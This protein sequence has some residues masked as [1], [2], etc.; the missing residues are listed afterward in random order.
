MFKQ[1]L[2]LVTE[3]INIK[4]IN[5]II[6]GKSEAVI[7]TGQLVSRIKLDE[8]TDICPNCLGKLKK[9][10]E[11][12][13]KCPN[14]SKYCLVKT[15]VV[16][17]KMVKVVCTEDEAR[18]IEMEY[19]IERLKH[20]IWD[21]IFIAINKQNIENKFLKLVEEWNNTL[22]KYTRNDLNFSLYAIMLVEAKNQ[23]NFHALSYFYKQQG[24][25]L[26]EEGKN[27][28]ELFALA[29]KY[30]KLYEKQ[31]GFRLFY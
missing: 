1:I 18:L 9:I 19:E 12:K 30:C 8:R 22:V 5:P 27:S 16:G 2:K 21:Q 25:V 3:N 17:N 7:Q 24:Y 29:E 4:V 23:N 31:T 6:S 14:C 28:S 15:K 13:T 10:P 26:R 20:W 11:A